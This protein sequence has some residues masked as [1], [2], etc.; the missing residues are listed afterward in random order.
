MIHIILLFCLLFWASKHKVYY[1]T[2]FHFSSFLDFRNQSCSQSLITISPVNSKSINIS[3]IPTIHY[4]DTTG[5]RD[6]NSLYYSFI[7]ASLISSLF[8][9]RCK[10]D[11]FPD[12]NVNTVQTRQ[13][14]VC[15]IK[16]QRQ[17]STA[18]DNRLYTILCAHPVNNG[19]KLL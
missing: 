13:S 3:D 16:E 11:K 18:K 2:A 1:I 17:F 19:I 12:M 5:D 10:S 9:H 8:F 4:C 7:A 15:I 14:S 6:S